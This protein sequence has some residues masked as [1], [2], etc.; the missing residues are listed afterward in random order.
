M[1]EPRREQ[2]RKGQA[3]DDR[4]DIE[5][6]RGAGRNPEP[7]F[8]IQ[9]SHRQRRQGDHGQEGE[10]DPRQGGGK[11]GF[12][13]NLT[14]PGRDDSHQPGREQ[15]AGNGDES[16]DD[17]QCIQDQIRQPPGRL[18]TFFGKLLGKCGDERRRQG[19][20]GEEIAQQIGDAE[21][22]DKRV[23]FAV[24][25]EQSREHLFADETEHAT[26]QHRE[27][28]RA[29][30]AGDAVALAHGFGAVLSSTPNCFRTALT[31]APTWMRSIQR[32]SIGHLRRK[33]G[34]HST[35]SRTMPLRGDSGPV[36][37]GEVEPQMLTVGVPSAAAI[38]MGP[39]SLVRSILQ[40]R[41]SAHR[42]SSVVGRRH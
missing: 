30:R 5:H 33:Q 4:A 1:K 3:A 17:D 26:A 20:F 6:H 16:E 27:A 42:S 13:G 8:G 40:N 15:D 41:S 19:A 37:S 24:G 2:E 32:K 38:C 28:D 25:P 31:T 35:G 36:S 22:R 18:I 10:H 14:K 23:E 9:H 7:V 11:F 39:V 29:R 34:L 12:T 21:R